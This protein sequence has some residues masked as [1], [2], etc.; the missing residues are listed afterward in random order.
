VFSFKLRG[1]YNKMAQLSATE[2]D[3]GVVTAS[4]G[5]HAQGLAYSARHMNVKASDAT[6]RHTHRRFRNQ[7]SWT[8]TAVPSAR[9][10]V[11][12]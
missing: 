11:E 4:A 5:N 9:P 8:R 6:S 12:A 7:M 1:A 3:K 10:A 2:K